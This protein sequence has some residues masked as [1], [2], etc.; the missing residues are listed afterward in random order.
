MR[1]RTVIGTLIAL[2]LVVLVAYLTQQNSGLLNESFALTD[3][4]AVPVYV[5]MVAVFLVGF[6]PVVSI[7]VVQ[8]LK[9]DLAER[10]D[11]RFDREADS[12]RS[13]FRRALDYRADGQW[14]QAAQN[15]EA[16][17]ATQPEDFAGLLHLGEVLRRQGRTEEA[18]ELHRR[19]SVLY[20]QSVAVLY[21]LAE[22]YS[23][24][25]TAEV[26]R[27][28]HDRILRDFPA[29]GLRILRLRRSLALERADWQDAQRLQDGIVALIGEAEKTTDGESEEAVV[30]GLAYELAVQALDAEQFDDAKSAFERILSEEPAFV[31]ARIM[32]GEALLLEG[33]ETGAVAEWRRGFETT[34]SP[35]FLQRIEDHFIERGD[36][37]RAIETL[38]AVISG[39]ENTLL[40]RFFLGRLYKRVEMNDEALRILQA[41]R[42]RVRR[43][44]TFYYLLARLYERRGELD[45]STSAYSTCIEQA[46]IPA[47]EYVCRT[48]GATAS[49][50]EAHC[51]PCGAWNSI[52]LDLEEDRT[53]DSDLG[54]KERPV[55]TAWQERTKGVNRR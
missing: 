52:E 38:H 47:S 6:L 5:V 19:A 29:S 42:D 9:R 33:D 11:R 40:P 49:S 22:D 24:L 43:S 8:A 3:R 55:W 45:K 53:Y 44:P 2:V 46:G 15:F 50:W 41:V 7:L 14:Q 31:P 13:S 18:L 1:I 17:L 30:R 12:A 37:L 25:G 20:P 23:A 34:G 26:A 21:E 39:A 28:L 4:H 27:E 35:T 48:C 54:L 16:A 32:L 10:R 36:P 51:D